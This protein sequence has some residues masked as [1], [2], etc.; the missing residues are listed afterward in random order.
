MCLK[1]GRVRA[2]VAETG[3]DVIFEANRVFVQPK[4]I[5]TSNPPPLPPPLQTLT[6]IPALMSAPS[7]S[8]S[9][10]SLHSTPRPSPLSLSFYSIPTFESL[11]DEIQTAYFHALDKNNFAPALALLRG[12]TNVTTSFMIPDCVEVELDEDDTVK[13]TNFVSLAVRNNDLSIRV[14]RVKMTT[15]KSKAAGWC[16]PNSTE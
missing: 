11:D 8:S 16:N 4:N 14:K 10:S 5:V 15:D 13:A 9:L 12:G 6:S 7:S 3:F 1:R 2:A